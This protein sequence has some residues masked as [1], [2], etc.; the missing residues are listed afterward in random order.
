MYIS[1]KN[2]NPQ[3]IMMTEELIRLK[4]IGPIDY[5][6][7]PDKIIYAKFDASKKSLTVKDIDESLLLL[8]EQ[9]K[10]Q[11]QAL[12]V[13][14]NLHQMPSLPIEVR[15]HLRSKEVSQFH[16]NSKATALVISNSLSRL[17]GNL[18]LTLVTGQVIKLFA[19]EEKAMDWLKQL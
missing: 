9:A 14:V 15:K 3:I 11:G 17:L 19:T 4:S 16:E 10:I 5:Y 13:L 12:L 7:R 8:E 18:L 2:I 6:L 1:G